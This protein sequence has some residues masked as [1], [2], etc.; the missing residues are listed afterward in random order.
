MVGIHHLAAEILA[1]EGVA[2]DAFHHL[3]AKRREV[4]AELRRPLR[5]AIE[6]FLLQ[7]HLLVPLREIILVE[8]LGIIAQIIGRKLHIARFTQP[9]IAHHLMGKGGKAAVFPYQVQML[10]H[11]PYAEPLVLSLHQGSHLGNGFLQFLQIHRPAFHHQVENLVGQRMFLLLGM[12]ELE[13]LV[14]DN[15]KFRQGIYQHH[16]FLGGKV[17]IRNFRPHFSRIIGIAEL[18]FVPG[19][20]QR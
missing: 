8:I 17:D 1:H 9:F 5:H 19:Y 3:A 4:L 10:Q 13:K 2:P 7:K 12:V 20:H 11:A 15:L 14:G 16:E 18:C 6:L